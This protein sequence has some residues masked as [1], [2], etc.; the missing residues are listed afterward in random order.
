MIDERQS[1]ELTGGGD[2][3]LHFHL[4]DRATPRQIQ[5]LERI[6]AP[7]T[8][9]LVLP[10]DDYVF[11]AASAPYTITL[12]VATN[13]RVLTIV[14]TSGTSTIT[15]ARSGTDTI[16][17]ASSV[18]ITTSYAPLCLKAVPGVGYIQASGTVAITPDAFSVHRNGADQ[19]GVQT[20]TWTKFIPTTEEFDVH[21]CYDLTTDNRFEALR[22]GP[23]MFTGATRCV[24][25]IDGMTVAIAFYVNG[26][27]KRIFW[28]RADYSGTHGGWA[29]G[30]CI[31]NLAINDYVEMYLYHSRGTNED[32]A[33]AA[34]DTFFSG[35]SL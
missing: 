8:T 34:T 19:T 2:T 4:A 29:N 22:A 6:A 12:P 5:N 11:A 14:R 25:P 9:Y 24:N 35:S 32:F 23:H 1:S 15:V 31:L 27:A 17:G 20:E 33:G 13:G 21:S 30:T 3:L 7:S 10:D 28:T 16:N 26:V 18:N